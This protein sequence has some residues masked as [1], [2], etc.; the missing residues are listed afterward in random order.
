MLKF[1]FITLLVIRSS[2][3]IFAYIGIDLGPMNL[4]IPSI[5][6]LLMILM[7]CTYIFLRG[8][9]IPKLAIFYSILLVFLGISIPVSLSN[10]GFAGM[11]AFRE[12]VRLATIFSVFVLSYNMFKKEQELKHLVNFCLLSLVIPLSVAYYQLIANIRVSGFRVFGTFPHANQFALYLLL[13]IAITYWKYVITKRKYWLLFLLVEIIVF[14]ATFSISGYLMFI[15]L[16]VL[17]FLHF[18]RSARIVV[19][20]VMVM[21]AILVANKD[22]FQKRIARIRQFDT[23]GVLEERKS[24]G[25]IGWRIN[26]WMDLLELSKN[27]PLLGYGLDTYI[28]Y[29]NYTETEGSV[30]PHNDYMKFLVETGFVGLLFYLLFIFGTSYHLYKEFKRTE[31]CEG[32]NLIYVLYSISVIWII[33]SGVGNIMASTAFHFYYWALIG[34]ALRYG[35]INNLESFYL[36]SKCCRKKSTVADRRCIS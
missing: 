13:F 1:F 26:Y 22:F 17:L 21:F 4:N 33:W 28:Y 29:G 9:K 15:L 14:I 19:I 25:S 36:A 5:L 7:V 6:G 30:Y 3:D 27:K 32:K 20:S 35:R 31:N 16:S 34:V 8:V 2:L 23:V 10:Y 18:K 24:I 12:W 11:I